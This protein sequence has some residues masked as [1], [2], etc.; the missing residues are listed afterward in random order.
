MIFAIN[1][2]RLSDEQLMERAADGNERAFAELY[3][4]YARRLQSF[5]FRQLAGDSE[6]AADF[7]HDTFLRIFDARHQY[8]QNQS[9][10]TW[11]FSVAYNLCKNRYCHLQVETKAVTMIERQPEVEQP[12]VEVRLNR[13]ELDVAL[14]SVLNSLPDD[15][16]ML[17]A[18][19]FEEDL[20]VAQ[21]A[22][23][24]QLPEG[25]VKSR[26]H[27]IMNYI[28]QQLRDYETR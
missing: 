5:L 23:I 16:R 18:L 4:R 19:R 11:L 26:Q 20:T 17:F 13:E 28:K 25:T 15:D 8:R 1:L 12:E 10:Q 2:S 27:K 14:R 22:A 21:T 7:T 24:M 3:N 9:F 6:L